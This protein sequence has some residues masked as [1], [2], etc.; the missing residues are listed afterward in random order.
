[1]I[2]PTQ[3][4]A[5][6]AGLAAV[7]IIGG[8]VLLGVQPAL[9]AASSD[10]QSADAVTTQ[11]QTTQVN[12]AGLAKLA[13]KQPALEVDQERLTKAL[14]ATLKPNTFVR[15]VNELAALDGVKVESVTPG[16]GEIYKAPTGAPGT[17]G[18]KAPKLAATDPRVTGANLTV[19]PMVVVVS[20]AKT[21]LE[22]FTHD[23]QNDERL[24]LVSGWSLAVDSEDVSKTT[25]TLTGS[26]YA[27]KR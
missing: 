18:A 3:R 16:A 10:D 4:W 5:I 14:P 2:G 22:R 1:M 17:G 7:A 24:F 12:L 19:V 23:L 20:G 13:A 25:A 21:A 26:I 8:G 27:L 6:G 11:I 15:R 9:S